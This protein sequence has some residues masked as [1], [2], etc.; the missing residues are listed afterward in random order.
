MKPSLFASRFS[1]WLPTPGSILFTLLIA[2][3]L[4]YVQRADALLG[5]PPPQTSSVTSTTTLP[6]QGR[7]HDP[8]GNPITATLPITFRFYSTSA[9]GTAFWTESWPGVEVTDG[10]FNVLL[11]TTTP[12]TPTL[13][14]DNATLWL[15]IQVAADAEMTPR[16]QLGSVPFAQQELTVPSGA[17]STAHLQDGAV[18]SEKLALQNEEICLNAPVDIPLAGNWEIAPIPEM[19]IPFTLPDES[20]ILLWSSGTY[21]FNIANY[22]I[23]T[24]IFLDDAE[25]IRSSEYTPFTAWNDFSIMRQVTISAGAHTLDLRTFAQAAGTITYGGD[26]L[27][28]CLQFLVLN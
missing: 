1:K 24:T 2:T 7:L 23:G 8:E 20:Q 13:F 17:I 6:Y 27:E 26:G 14:T 4:L 9:G 19:S 28:T 18:T 22:H 11:G 10:L 25:L 5:L 3:L 16:V 21:H 12:L 15:G